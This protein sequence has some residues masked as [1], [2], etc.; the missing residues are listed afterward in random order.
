MKTLMIDWQR[1]VDAG[2]TCPRCGDTQHEVR[3]AAASLR[4]ALAPL[5]V[6][7]ELREGELSTAEFAAA[8]L[9]SNR[10]LLQGRT[11]EDWLGGETGQ[12]ACCDVCGPDDCR[13][14]TVD[15]T[16]HETIPA[17]LI[18]RAGL[19]AAA[20]L[21]AEEPADP[22]PCCAPA[23]AGTTIPIAEVRRVSGRRPPE[24][25]AGDRCC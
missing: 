2:R 25:A 16:T 23:Q 10:I 24:G 21:L 14:V 3:E 1:L 5:G 4:S 20:A 12:S 8:P 17:E 7:V 22:A 6:Q 15:G 18:V 13:T 11:V 9:E 19:L